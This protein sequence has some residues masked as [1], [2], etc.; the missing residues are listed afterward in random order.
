MLIAL[1]IG[2]SRL[3]LGVHYLTDVVAGYVAGIAWTD[4][5]I[6][7]GHLLT[8]RRLGS[9]GGAGT[10]EQPL[11]RRTSS[12]SRQ[13]GLTGAGAQDVA[14]RQNGARSSWSRSR[15]SRQGASSWP[16]GCGGRV[17]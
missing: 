4:A 16:S 12:R 10:A 7:G 2:L 13:P 9:R 3:Y 1:L 11:P 8:R 17:V 5:V 6:I 15:P 14:R